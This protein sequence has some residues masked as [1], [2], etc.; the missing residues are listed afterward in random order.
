MCN[1]VSP[2][3]HEILRDISFC[4]LNQFS[5]LVFVANL[6]YKWKGLVEA[7]L[8]TQCWPP[9]G[10]C[11]EGNVSL[12]SNPLDRV[13]AIVLYVFRRR[14]FNVF[15][16]VFFPVIHPCSLYQLG[17][18]IVFREYKDR[19]NWK[20]STIVETTWRWISLTMAE[21]LVP[22]LHNFLHCPL[23][24]PLAILLQRYLETQPMTRVANQKDSPSFLGSAHQTACGCSKNSQVLRAWMN[25]FTQ[26]MFAFSP[27]SNPGLSCK[28]YCGLRCE[29]SDLLISASPRLLWKMR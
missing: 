12:L 20:A 6:G 29:E 27:G 17:K 18:H 26:A 13:D 11:Y 7:N 19:G 22:L 25:S 10:N 5:Q 24:Y 16:G 4:Q 9:T 8:L 3:P 23:H 2:W 1:S 21:E 28:M 14:F 15:L